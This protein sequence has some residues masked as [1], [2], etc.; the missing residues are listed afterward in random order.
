MEYYTC[1][2]SLPVGRSIRVDTPLRMLF[3]PLSFHIGVL[4]NEVSDHLSLHG[5]AEVVLY[6]EFTQLN[7]L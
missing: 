3:C 1:S 6:V 4:R 2:A 7:C 5:S